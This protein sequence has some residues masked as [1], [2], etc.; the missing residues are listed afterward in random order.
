M[1]GTLNGKR[2]LKTTLDNSGENLFYMAFF[3][4]LC[5]L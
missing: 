5:K 1:S 2:I 3:G 4:D